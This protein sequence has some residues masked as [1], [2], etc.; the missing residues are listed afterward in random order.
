MLLGESAA[1]KLRRQAGRFFPTIQGDRKEKSSSLCHTLSFLLVKR[2]AENSVK[3]PAQAVVQSTGK[4]LTKS[5]GTII[6]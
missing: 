4:Y 2:I 5:D 3:A 1:E 6:L